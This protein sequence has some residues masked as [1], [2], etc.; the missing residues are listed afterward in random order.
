VA[1][2]M[3]RRRPATLSALARV[4]W[5][6]AIVFGYLFLV[7]IAFVDWRHGIF[8][9]WHMPDQHWGFRFYLDA[10][11]LTAVGFAGVG[12]PLIAWLAAR[13]VRLRSK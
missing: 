5:L 4:A 2:W 6:A 13:L 9:R 11:A 8:M 1:A 7:R 10:L 3:E 12:F